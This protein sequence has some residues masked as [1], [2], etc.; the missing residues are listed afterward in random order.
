MSDRINIHSNPTNPKFRLINSITVLARLAG[1]M[2]IDEK[3]LLQGSGLQQKDLNDPLKLITF[4]Q[5][6][7]IAQK[8]II[9]APVPG[10]GLDVGLDYNFS[11]SGKL[12]M[13]MMCCDTVLDALKLNLKYLHLTASHFRY[14]LVVDGDKACGCFFELVNLGRNRPFFCE[15]EVA[16]LYAMAEIIQ[17][18]SPYRELHFTYPEPSYAS[19]YMERFHCPVF[20]NAPCNMIVFDPKILSIPLTMANPL[21]RNTLEQDCIHLMDC[22]QANASLSA[23]I[24]KELAL[25][26]SDFPS[27]EQMA[28]RV[29]L[30]PRTFRRRLMEEATSYK[31]LLSS[32]RKDKAEELLTSTTLSMEKVAER[33]GFSEVSSFYR[34]FKTWT[35]KTPKHYRKNDEDQTSQS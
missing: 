24:H 17:L 31:T 5:Q 1:R 35:G 30:S 25:M 9:L 8:F 2:G 32:I 27:L 20:F 16:S 13:A 18:K 29:N 3:T 23:R 12:G 19:K 28:K 4:E 6:F 34:A 15:S 33:L 11:A 10:V 14:H 7:E 21:V 26:K 22:L